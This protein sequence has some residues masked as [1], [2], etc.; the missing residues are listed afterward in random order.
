MVA[1]VKAYYEHVLRSADMKG[2]RMFD[3]LNHVLQT[4]SRQ[5]RPEEVRVTCGIYRAVI[6]RLAQ[7]Q[8]ATGD[9]PVGWRK[10]QYWWDADERVDVALLDSDPLPHVCEQI[11]V[12]GE[13]LNGLERAINKTAGKIDVDAE[14]NYRSQRE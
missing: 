3:C 7:G 6:H 9:S 4:A 1:P 14:A 13:P 10:I 5:M 12:V 2:D 11:R 8:N